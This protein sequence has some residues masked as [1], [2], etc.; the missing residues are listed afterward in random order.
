VSRVKGTYAL[1]LA[2]DREALITVGRLITFTFPVGYYIYVGS[3]L[4]GLFHRIERHI[5]GGKKLHWHIDYLRREA[6][7][8]EV[9]YRISGERLECDWY[10]AAAGMP[11][12]E[13]LVDGFGSSGCKC[14]SHLV[15]FKLKPSLKDFRR[16]LGKQGAELKRATPTDFHASLLSVAD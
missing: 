4:G 8:I 5:R 16:R 9:W 7:V 15:Y 1:V 13:V 14:R 11:E 6:R 10:R 3:G 12:A 2:L